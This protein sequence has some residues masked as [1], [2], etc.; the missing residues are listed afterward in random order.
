[1]SQ[2][3]ANNRIDLIRLVILIFIPS[4]LLLAYNIG[5]Q[6]QSEVQ[7]WDRALAGPH[8]KGLFSSHVCLHIAREPKM[9]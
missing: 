1:M 4:P 5:V 9:A 8:S 2:S 7:W 3:C 6:A